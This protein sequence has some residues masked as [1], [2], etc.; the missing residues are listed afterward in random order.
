MRWCGDFAGFAH[1]RNI[2]GPA[3]VFAL[4]DEAVTLL[5]P[6][7]PAFRRRNTDKDRALDL[8]QTAAT[9]SATLVAVSA[10][11][12]VRLRRPLGNSASRLPDFFLLS[13]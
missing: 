5:F 11:G 13:H 2:M 3:S 7:W 8:F 6:R 1:H 9:V 4:C 10:V 12:K